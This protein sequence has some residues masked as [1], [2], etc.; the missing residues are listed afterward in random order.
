MAEPATVDGPT[1]TAIL[2]APATLMSYWPSHSPQ[3]ASSPGQLSVVAAPARHCDS[4]PVRTRS[5]SP[6]SGMSP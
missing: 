3:S 1:S 2:S 4:H 6:G 5:A